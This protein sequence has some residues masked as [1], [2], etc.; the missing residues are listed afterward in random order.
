MFD[1]V[2]LVNQAGLDEQPPIAAL[3]PSTFPDRLTLCLDMDDT[4]TLMSFEQIKD[5]KG[6]ILKY[7]STVAAPDNPED[8]G[9]VYFRPFLRTFLAAVSAKFEVVVFT[10]A[11][12]EYAD[13]ILDVIDPTKSLIHHRL[14][15]DD[16]RECQHS[17][18]MVYLKDL[19]VL[20]RDLKRTILVDNSLL[21]FACQLDNGIVCNPFR[22]NQDD[23]ELITILHVLTIVTAEPQIDDVRRLFR[24]MYGLSRIM[25]EYQLSGG[26]YGVN[27][28]KQFEN[29]DTM[30][31][32]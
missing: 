4:L 1:F 9:M 30:L 23:S 21:C 11:C 10:A 16:C 27:R 20:N 8:W 2:S 17:E 29:L 12:K 24:K 18:G 7:D 5:S 26:R 22:G 13:Q 28:K 25:A 6:D 14:Y 3:P 19:R 32:E 15:R 31:R